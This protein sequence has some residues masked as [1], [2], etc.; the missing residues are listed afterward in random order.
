LRGDEIQVEENSLKT[1]AA[2]DHAN[3]KI[4]GASASITTPIA[5]E[6]NRTVDADLD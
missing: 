2:S 5:A 6:V 1:K 3:S 4:C